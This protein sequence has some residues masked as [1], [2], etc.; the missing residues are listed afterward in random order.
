[1]SLYVN[2]LNGRKE[3]IRREG[4][5]LFMPLKMLTQLIQAYPVFLELLTE[6][7][8]N[9]TFSAKNNTYVG[10]RSYK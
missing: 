1:M 5:S 9:V 3:Q 8:K 4:G 6:Y 7:C 10:N 2:V